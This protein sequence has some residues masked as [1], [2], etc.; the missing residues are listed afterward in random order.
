VRYGRLLEKL[1]RQDEA[2]THYEEVLLA[3]DVAPRHYRKAQ[4]R[5]IG[6]ARESAKR[7]NAG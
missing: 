6:E 3:T 1:G 7:I 4:R 2:L 5:W